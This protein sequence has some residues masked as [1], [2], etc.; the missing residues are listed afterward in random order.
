MRDVAPRLSIDAVVPSASDAGMIPSLDQGAGDRAD[1]TME[2]DMGTPRPQGDE[3]CIALAQCLS[4]CEEADCSLLCR[5]QASDEAKMLYDAIFACGSQHACNEPGGAYNV[6]CMNDNCLFELDSCYGP[7]P[8]GPPPPMGEGTCQELDDCLRECEADDLNCRDNCV[9][10]SSQMSF[11]QLVA[12]QECLTN[13]ECPEGDIA[14]LLA[15][16]E[17][18]LAGCYGSVSVPRGMAE[19]S[20]YNDCLNDCPQG[21]DACVSACAR[22]ASPEGYNVFQSLINCVRDSDCPAQDGDCQRAACGPQFE[23]CFGPPTPPPMGNGDCYELN[24][25]LNECAEGDRVCT[26]NCVSASSQMAYDLFVAAIDCLQNADCPADDGDC[27]QMA[28]GQQIEACIGPSPMP[29]G[30]LTCGEFNNCLVACM[31]GDRR[32][33]DGCINQASPEGYRRFEAAID[34]IEEAGCQPN[35]AN[36]QQVNC[37]IEISACINH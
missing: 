3:A 9:V 21:D 14:C 4:G 24:R 23:A 33:V 20:G 26:D 16:C 2:A 30:V 19:C 12:M 15:T 7:P 13:T 18:E 17:M 29:T 22:S 34:C 25:C 28:C 6:E 35:D 10:A 37:G 8:P 1:A 36:C 11:D 27:R 5:N 31:D 32:C